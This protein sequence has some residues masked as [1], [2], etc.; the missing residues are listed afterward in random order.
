MSEI[1]ESIFDPVLIKQQFPLLSERHEGQPNLVYLDSAATSQKPI[2]VINAITD[3]Y[4]HCNANVHRGVYELSHQATIRYEACRQTVRHFINAKAN[5]E[6]VFTSGATASMNCVAHGFGQSELS[7]G[8]EVVMSVME[9]HSTI[10]PWQMACKASGASLKIIPMQDNG[11]LDLVAYR[12]LLN[13][14]TKVVVLMH[15]SNALG[16]INPIQSMIA[17]AHA[18]GIPVVI[19][20]AQAPSHVPIDVTALDCEF[21]TF[22]GHKAYGPTGVGVL[23][24]K[25]AW[26]ER[27]PPFHCGGDMIETV[28]FEKT[29]FNVLP[30]KF[31]AGTPNIAGVIG[32]SE[33]LQFIRSM[34]LDRIME[35]EQDLLQYAMFRLSTIDGLTVYGTSAAKIGII[36]FT[37]QQAHPHD[38]ATI[39]A[40]RGVAVR[41]GHHCA[42]P[43]M[44][45]LE[46]PATVRASFAMHTTRDDVDRLVEGLQAVLAIFGDT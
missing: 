32:L 10:V 25:R 20:G 38:I 21:Y 8:D 5:E 37:L 17:D 26:L 12:A 43:L 30:Y 24:G 4:S 13:D 31:E 28:S 11:E 41:A 40:D 36:S 23:Y 16:T 19:D 29:T 44:A 9:H 42:M 3:Y 39:L 22:S 18:K 1:A 34:G 15:V 14:K 45:R 6:I 27:L 35:H 2:S 46:V 33:A 7:A